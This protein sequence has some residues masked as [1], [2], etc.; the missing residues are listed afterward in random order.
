MLGCT[1]TFQVFSAISRRVRLSNI[2]SSAFINHGLDESVKE[3]QEWFDSTDSIEA[4]EYNEKLR[5]LKEQM[6]VYV[7][8]ENDVTSR[9]EKIEKAYTKLY[10]LYDSM[11]KM[12]GTKEWVP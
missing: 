3:I 1:Y 2:N 8:R 11:L 9:D 10:N 5:K 7:E 12:N 4:Y 6:T